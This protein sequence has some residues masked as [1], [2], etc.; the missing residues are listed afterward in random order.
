MVIEQD[1]DFRASTISMAFSI[2]GIEWELL[3]KMPSLSPKVIIGGCSLSHPHYECLNPF[4]VKC[5]PKCSLGLIKC[6]H[7]L[8]LSLV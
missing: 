1:E 8:L 5:C 3:N 2:T 4:G 6:T 7:A